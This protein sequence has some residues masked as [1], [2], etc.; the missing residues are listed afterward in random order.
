MQGLTPYISRAP[1]ADEGGVIPNGGSKNG[2]LTLGDIDTYSFQGDAGDRVSIQVGD[3]GDGDTANI[4]P[5]LHLYNPDGSLRGSDSSGSVAGLIN[6]DMRQTGTYTVQISHR[7]VHGGSGAGPY[8]VHLA[9]SPG[10][11]E[12]GLLPNGGVVNGA[13]TLGDIDTYTF[14][15]NAGDTV[16]VQV[17][18]TGDGQNANISPYLFIYNPD[19]SFRASDSGGAV[20]GALNIFPAV[21]IGV[22]MRG[23]P[24]VP[25]HGVQRCRL[26]CDH[27]HPTPQH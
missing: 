12:G 13:L 20:A 6:Y 24:R 9:K 26:T 22:C 8:A 2:A 18:D 17:S 21:R 19:G 7:S 25:V 4:S 1:G 3:T 15:A 5:Y 11:D 14:V 23:I 27:L 16:S 10:A